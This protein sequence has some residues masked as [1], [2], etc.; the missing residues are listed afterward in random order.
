MPS[1]VNEAEPSEVVRVRVSESLRS[2]CAAARERGAHAGDAES[3]FLGYL[4]AVE[5]ELP[6]EER[7]FIAKT[8]KAAYRARRGDCLAHVVPVYD[9][10]EARAV[11]NFLKKLR[12]GK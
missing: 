1:R 2:K 11:D 12:A 7:D 10:G 8:L 5:E 9:E 6:A 3:S 4:L